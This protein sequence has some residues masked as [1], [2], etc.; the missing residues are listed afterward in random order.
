MKDDDLKIQTG[1]T[2][3]KVWYSSTAMNFMLHNSL[4]IF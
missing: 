4:G 1:F 2:E 3:S